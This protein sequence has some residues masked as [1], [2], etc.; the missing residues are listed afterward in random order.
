M[1]PSPLPRPLH[2]QTENAPRSERDGKLRSSP[3]LLPE[4][5]LRVS[6]GYPRSSAAAGCD[7]SREAKALDAAAAAASADMGSVLRSSLLRSRCRALL[8]AH[9]HRS[10]AVRSS[11][12]KTTNIYIYYIY[13]TYTES[14][15]KAESGD[16]LIKQA[17]TGTRGVCATAYANRKSQIADHRSQIEN[18]LVPSRAH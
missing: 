9:R 6:L 11:G 4:L 16:C 13:I 10:R 14:V 7:C 17:L 8:V 3:A 2:L 15:C 18:V 1:Q 5:Q 12:S